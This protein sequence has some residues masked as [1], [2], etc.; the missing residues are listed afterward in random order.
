MIK[1][2][3]ITC[4]DRSEPSEDQIGQSISD[5]FE[6]C[7]FEI[8]GREDGKHKAERR[9]HTVIRGKKRIGNR[10]LKVSC[11][12]DITKISVGGKDY[13]MSQILIENESNFGSSGDLYEE[14]FSLFRQ[15]CENLS[16]YVAHFNH[17]LSSA[18]N[19]EHI[20]SGVPSIS[21]MSYYSYELMRD[22]DMPDTAQIDVFELDELRDGVYVRP[23]KEYRP[24]RTENT[25]HVEEVLGVEFRD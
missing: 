17:K 6:Q 14:V 18:G 7:G 15:V 12:I 3:A 20:E 4:I 1:E 16:P 23:D 10:E 9:S 24:K 22:V 13:Y 2:T 11:P 5:T 21:P 8:V 25:K 19:P